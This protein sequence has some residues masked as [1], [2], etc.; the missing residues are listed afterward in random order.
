[1][2]TWRRNAINDKAREKYLGKVQDDTFDRWKRADPVQ[3]DK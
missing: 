1:M 2:D 3:R